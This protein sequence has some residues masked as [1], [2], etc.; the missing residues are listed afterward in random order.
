MN[1]LFRVSKVKSKGK[2]EAKTSE[3]RKFLKPAPVNIFYIRSDKK[4]VISGPSRGL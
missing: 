2:S 4:P 1:K 3:D